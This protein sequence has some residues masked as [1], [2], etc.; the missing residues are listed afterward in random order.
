MGDL[1]APLRTI[2]VAPPH[3]TT[4]DDTDQERLAEPNAAREP[5][6]ERLDMTLA[7]R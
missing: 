6:Q 3:Q 4:L 7:T 1:G 2:V 5:E